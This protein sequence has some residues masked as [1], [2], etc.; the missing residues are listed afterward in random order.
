MIDLMSALRAGRLVTAALVATAV[1][2]LAGCGGSGGGSSPAQSQADS[3]AETPG[4][5]DSPVLHGSNAPDGGSGG[6]TQLEPNQPTSGRNAARLLGQASF[7]ATRST[8]ARVK[9]IGARKY[10]LEQ[11]DAPVSQYAYATRELDERARIHSQATRDG[12]CQTFGSSLVGDCWRDYYSA[13]P[14]QREFYRQA[15]S[16]P[17]Q[18]RQRMAFALSQILVTSSRELDSSYGFATYHQLLRNHAFDN[19]RT[20]LRQVTLSPFM[21]AYLNMVDNDRD[22]PNENY[23]RELL[24]LFSL[25]ACQLEAD[26]TLSGG[27]CIETYDNEIVRNYAFA[28]TGWTFPA[29]GVDP[30]CSGSCRRWTQPRY[31][32]GQMV[33]VAGQHDDQP[34]QLLAG[35][36]A[37]GGR[38]AQQ[39]LEAV[40]DS[41]MAHPNMAPFIGRQLIQFF[42]TSNPTPGYVR[43]VA[44]AFSSGRFSDGSG[45]P[46]GSGQAGDLRAT[47]AAVLLDPEARTDA[48]SDDSR[49]GR[50]REPAQIIAGAIRV[51]EGMTDGDA[52]APEWAWAGLMGQ[53][54]F[55]APSVFNF[56][57]PDFPLTGTSLMAPQMGSETITSALARINFGYALLYW[58]GENGV[59]PNAT[60]P[61]AFGTRVNLM[62]WQ[63]SLT[64][65]GDSAAVVDELDLLLTGGRLTSA[66]KAIIVGAMDVWK[67]DQTWLENQNSNWRKERVKTAIYLV[68]ASPQYQVQR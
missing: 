44:Q 43:R 48:A 33:A 35:V 19:Y 58:W 25:G 11:M 68:L 10:L 61:G 39:G 18:L 59:T 63:R 26:G 34:R 54:P 3:L 27:R 53:P 67:P 23:A 46:I 20:V 5:A 12:F 17:D 37:P 40:L 50:L 24:Q 7:G 22:Q 1:M 65:T 64:G 30:W 41:L 36:T 42:V 32:R 56:Y 52:V 21:G 4:G 55:A 2:A 8:L 38:S 14:V 13:H 9:E 66:E 60:I 57:P 45:L 51:L 49:F 16:N 29:G 28:L 62:E 6:L 47:I 15:V 31:Y